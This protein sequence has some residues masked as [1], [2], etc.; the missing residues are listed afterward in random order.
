M[1]LLLTQYI[2]SMDLLESELPSNITVSVL[3]WQRMDKHVCQ[4][5]GKIV[6]TLAYYFAVL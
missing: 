1:L 6:R 2:Y 5:P 3:L 4:V